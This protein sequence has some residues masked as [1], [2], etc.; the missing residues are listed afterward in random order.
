M[1]RTADDDVPWRVQGAV[2]ATGLFSNSSFHLYNL[3]IPLWVVTLHPSP[4]L[5]GVALGSRQFLTIFLSI[6]GGA[7]MDRL[8]TRRVMI[9]CAGTAV[10]VPLAYPLVPWMPALIGLQMVGGL[11]VMLCWIGAQTLVGQVMRGRPIYAGRLSFFTRVGVFVGPPAAGATWDLLGPWGGFGAIALWA[12]GMFVGSI[13]LPAPVRSDEP[14]GETPQPGTIPGLRELMP[15]LGDYVAAFRLVSVPAIALILLATLAR[16]SGVS[17]QGSFYVVYLQEIGITGTAIGVLLSFSGACGAAGTLLVGRLTRR[18]S[19]FGLLLGAV[20]AT[21]VFISIT[22][23][24]GTYFALLIAIGMRGASNGISQALEISQMAQAADAASQ[25]KAV[26]LRITA[27]R[28]AAFVVPVIMGG[29]VE[30]TGLEFGFYIMG[31]VILLSL[32]VGGMTLR[33]NG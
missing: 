2:Y 29:V 11:A 8:G 21:V 14:V 18:F 27:G 3:I 30:F 33:R 13:L 16:H 10:V 32:L 31:G 17:M 19:A 4:F 28:L 1:S 20:A 26:A 6:H 24:L 9:V 5:I 12:A 23:L 15:N 7:L 22:P 25:G